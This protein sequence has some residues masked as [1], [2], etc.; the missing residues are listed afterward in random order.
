MNSSNSRPPALQVDNLTKSFPDFSLKQV[1]FTVPAG[2]VVGMVGENGSG[3]STCVRCILG[4]DIP[5]SGSIEILG[6]S[7]DKSASIHARIGTASDICP[8]PDSLNCRQ[9][10]SIL[11]DVY[12]GWDSKRFFSLLDQFSVPDR[13]PFRAFSKGMKVKA[14]LCAALS[15]GSDLL[16]LDEATAGLDPVVRE[17]ILDLLMEFMENENH[18]I[19]LTSH[20]TSDLERIADYILYIQNGEILFLE[21]K[22]V[23]EASGIARLRKDQLDFIDPELIVRRRQMPL[24][25]DLLIRDR[26]EFSRRYPD[27]VIEPAKIDDVI[28]MYSK[29][30]KL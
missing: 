21:E 29:G 24:S 9:I 5:D 27:Y 16:I 2:S 10:S 6:D 22:S 4:Q 3:K 11:Q 1:S 23:I 12:P 13:K 28:V 25:I 19:F 14:S 26:H 30:E 7:V 8:F 17:E 18:S 20:I 15:H